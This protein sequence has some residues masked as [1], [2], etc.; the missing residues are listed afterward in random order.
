[1]TNPRVRVHYYA[2]IADAAVTK[3]EDIKLL[4]GGKLTKSFFKDS[5]DLDVVKEID[6]EGNTDVVQFDQNTGLSHLEFTPVT[7]EGQP[8]KVI[9]IT[10]ETKG[11]DDA[12]IYALTP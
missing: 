2:D 1:M 8:L 4:P 3:F 12:L 6:S 7:V 9:K 5:F 11:I 10:G